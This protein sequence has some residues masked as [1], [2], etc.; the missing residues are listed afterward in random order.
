M[1]HKATVFET[2]LLGR[3]PYLGWHVQQSDIEQVEKTISYFGLEA[4]AN[5]SIVQLSGGE[6]QK[7][8]LARALAQEPEYLLL[9]EPINNLDLS[10]QYEFMNLLQKVCTEQKI[11]MLIILHDIDLALR[12]CN[13]FFLLKDTKTINIHD[14]EEFTE[15]I[16]TEIFDI[17][18]RFIEYEG[19][20]LIMYN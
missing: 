11:G 7:V 17:D 9:D 6:R 12:Y 18:V 19:Q 5:R 3:K 1:G 14:K 2:I 13:E 8:F 4:F 10:S 20:R 15:E 16:I